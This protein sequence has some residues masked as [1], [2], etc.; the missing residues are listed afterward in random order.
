MIAFFHTLKSN[1]DKFE[2]LARKYYPEGD[3]RHFVNEDILNFA[4]TQGHTNAKAFDAEIENIRRLH[5]DKIICTCSTYGEDSERHPDVFRIDRPIANYLVK[6]YHSIGL[7]YAA[8]STREISSRLIEQI[9]QENQKEVDIQVIDC[10]SAWP[11]FEQNKPHDY[12]QEIARCL[13]TQADRAEVILLAQASMEGA[14]A[15]LKDF[16]KEVWT[17]PEYGVKSL[18]QS[19]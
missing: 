12:A 7:A 13:R 2:Q 11:F 17:S 4:L 3:I 18:L 14:K 8:E 10:R 6:H 19:P 16:P 1:V 5:P 9:A 15:Y